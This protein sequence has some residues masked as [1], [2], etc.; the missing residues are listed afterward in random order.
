MVAGIQPALELPPSRRG[1]VGCGHILLSTPA[2]TARTSPPPQHPEKDARTGSASI[3]VGLWR[4]PLHNALPARSDVETNQNY[5]HVPLTLA[6]AC[7]AATGRAR[8]RGPWGLVVGAAAVPAPAVHL[9]TSG[10][11]AGWATRGGASSRP[12]S[13]PERPRVSRI[14]KG[15]RACVTSD[16]RPPSG[17]RQLVAT[18]GSNEV[19]QWWA[20]KWCNSCKVFKEGFW[21]FLVYR[22]GRGAY[23]A[24]AS[25]VSKAA[26]FPHHKT[27]G[28]MGPVGTRTGRA[29]SYSVFSGRL[30]S[31]GESEKGRLLSAPPRSPGARRRSALVVKGT[32]MREGGALRRCAEVTE[33][34]CAWSLVGALMSASTKASP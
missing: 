9:P 10:H 26:C 5:P 17:P 19:D 15:G 16:A 20:V 4:Y 14:Q 33:E 23:L 31:T 11:Q 27:R 34:T 28:R 1:W 6:T 18:L 2:L 32:E 21:G 30:L 8:R 12:A 29:H 7:F 22:R 25:R 24:T 3:A 13:H